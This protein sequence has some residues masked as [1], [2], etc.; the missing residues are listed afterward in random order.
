VITANAMGFPRFKLRQNQGGPSV[1]R[2]SAHAVGTVAVLSN[3]RQGTVEVAVAPPERDPD[4]ARSPWEAMSGAALWSGGRVIGLVAEHH[5]ADGP[6]RLAATRVAGPSWP[7]ALLPLARRS[8]PRWRPSAGPSTRSAPAEDTA[9]GLPG[10]RGSP[11]GSVGGQ[12]AARAV[13]LRVLRR[14]DR[15]S[16]DR[17]STAAAT[18]AASRATGV[19]GSAGRAAALGGWTRVD[20]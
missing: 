12:T 20:W 10:G 5:L 4:P 7:A 16:R 8:P 6:G 15:A 2:D 9:M 13:A 19:P 18:R 11:I 17:A 1:Y 14:T 3:R